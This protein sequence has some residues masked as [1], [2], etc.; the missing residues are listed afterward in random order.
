MFLESERTAIGEWGSAFQ[1]RVLQV[2]NLPFTPLKGFFF[3]SYDKIF[4]CILFTIER[5]SFKTF[6]EI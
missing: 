6:D 4:P 3:G 2:F 1:L 5:G